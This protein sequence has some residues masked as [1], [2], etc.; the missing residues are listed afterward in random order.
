MWGSWWYH[1]PKVH[2]RELSIFV[3]C[4]DLLWLVVTLCSCF[5]PKK[6]AKRASR[7]PKSRP[8]WPPWDWRAASADP[9]N[10]AVSSG[11]GTPRPPSRPGP[12][13][14]IHAPW[15]LL[16]TGCWTWMRGAV[17]LTVA[18]PPFRQREK[19]GNIRPSMDNWTKGKIWTSRSW[20]R[21]TS[22]TNCHRSFSSVF[23]VDICHHQR[24]HRDHQKSFRDVVIIIIISSSIIMAVFVTEMVCWATSYFWHPLSVTFSLEG[25]R[26]NFTS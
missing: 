14:T 7:K 24:Q 9:R 2:M 25:A 23:I 5:R 11:P 17:Q 19:L 26:K 8:A 22:L 16:G 18:E 4:C 6:R 13:A 12:R 15:R 3:T 21:M 20:Q 10:P 1:I